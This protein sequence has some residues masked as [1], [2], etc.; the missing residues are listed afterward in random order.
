MTLTVTPQRLSTDEKSSMVL[1]NLFGN[2]SL[3]KAPSDEKGM[4]WGK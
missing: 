2:Q 1:A 4:S 3:M